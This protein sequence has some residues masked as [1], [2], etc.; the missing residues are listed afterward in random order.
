MGTRG[1][2]ELIT[3]KN[4]DKS[5]YDKMDEKDYERLMIKTNALHRDYDPKNPRPRGNRSDKW[6]ELLCPIWDK[7]TALSS[8]ER[9]KNLGHGIGKSLMGRVLLSCR[10]I[11]MHC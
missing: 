2:W 6:T 5:D 8:K 11:L 9:E 1:L 3:L 10:V 4:L 7:Y